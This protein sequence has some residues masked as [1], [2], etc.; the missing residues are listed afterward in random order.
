MLGRLLHAFRSRWE[1][2]FSKFADTRAIQ[3]EL[4]RRS[5]YCRAAIEYD[6]IFFFVDAFIFSYHLFTFSLLYMKYHQQ[7]A[8]AGSTQENDSTAFGIEMSAMANMCGALWRRI[9]AR[10]IY[11][12]VSRLKLDQFFFLSC[13]MSWALCHGAT[14][15]N[16]KNVNWE[17]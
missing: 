9:T 7:P 2:F 8:A 4:F 11:R 15:Y 6:R 17:F 1:M 3:P 13:L 12:H 14:L 5:Y 10:S 16:C